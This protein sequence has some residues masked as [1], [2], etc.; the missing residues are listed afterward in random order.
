M[1]HETI[2]HQPVRISISYSSALLFRGVIPYASRSVVLNLDY[3]LNH[4]EG[5]GIA[6]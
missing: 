6:Q 4:S 3:D 2:Y 1:F 5:W